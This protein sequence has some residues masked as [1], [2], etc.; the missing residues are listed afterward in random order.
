MSPWQHDPQAWSGRVGLGWMQLRVRDP[1]VRE[2]R[3]LNHMLPEILYC[4]SPGVL[5]AFL[6]QGEPLPGVECGSSGP[7]GCILCS[8]SRSWVRRAR[9]WW[10][11]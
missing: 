3:V 1:R 9:A 4:L 2:E 6:E 10:V 11:E 5:S 7:A 8:V